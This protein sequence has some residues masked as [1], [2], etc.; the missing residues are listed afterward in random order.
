MHA[1]LLV[2]RLIHILS[3][4]A[5]LGSGVFTTFF[6]VPALSSSPEV[7]G[8]VLAGLQRRRY[9]VFSQIVAGLTILSGLR[10][11]WID[12]AGFNSGYFATGTGRMFGI[13]GAAAIIAAVLTLGIAR[14]AAVRAG[15][16]SAQLSAAQD[17]R[18]RERLLAELDP[19][20]R[21]GTRATILGVA[22]GILAASGM[23]IARYV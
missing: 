3:G 16:I 14:S 19:L 7:M 10:L 12:S 17:A 13:S 18:E 21:R 4:I 5:W 23:A 6:L 9:F 2:L 20:R 11:L 8:Q 15:K 1:E 22:F